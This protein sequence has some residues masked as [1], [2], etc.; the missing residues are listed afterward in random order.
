MSYITN[1]D[2]SVNLPNEEGMI[3]WLQANFPMSGY[4]VVVVSK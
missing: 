4:R 2:Q 3:E 1:K